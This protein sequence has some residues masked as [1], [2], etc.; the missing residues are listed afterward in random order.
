MMIRFARASARSVM[1]SSQ[2]TGLAL[3]ATA[4]LDSPRL[5]TARAILPPTSPSPR[6]RTRRGDELRYPSI[7]PPGIGAAPGIVAPGA[8]VAAANAGSILFAPL[9]SV[10]PGMGRH[11]P[12]AGVAV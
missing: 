1:R 6:R 11:V 8:P 10:E 9:F 12:T 4:T 7:R 2:P 3:V 5:A